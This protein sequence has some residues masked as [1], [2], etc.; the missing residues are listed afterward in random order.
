MGIQHKKRW[1]F[2]SEVENMNFLINGAR[3][4]FISHHTREENPHESEI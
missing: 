1:H 2:K 4:A 3:A